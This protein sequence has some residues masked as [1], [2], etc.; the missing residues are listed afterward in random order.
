MTFSLRQAKR[1][2]NRRVR[3]SSVRVTDRVRLRGGLNLVDSAESIEAGELLVGKNYEPHFITQAY[4]RVAGYEVFDGQPRPHLAE[5]WKVELT[6]ITGGP[7][8]LGE[9]V[10]ASKLGETSQTGIVALYIVNESESDDSG[11]LIITDLSDD[12]DDGFTWVGLTST[13]S[14]SAAGGADYQG[15]ATEDDHDA[16][17]LAAEQLRRG[18]IGT[19]GGGVCAGS[20]TGVHIYEDEVYAFRNN[21]LGTAGTMWKATAAGWVQIALGYKIRFITG[22]VNIYEGDTI[23]G[24]LSGA[25][26]TVMKVSV[27][28]GLMSGG[29]G[30][31]YII[32]NEITAGP[33]TAAEDLQVSGSTVAV[34]SSTVAQTL[35]PDGKYRFRN[36]NFGGNATSFSMYGANGVGNAFEYDGT[37]FTL[38]ETGMVVDTP[39]HIGVHRGQLLL[40]YAGGSLQHSGKNQP[41]SFQP[42]S[43]ANEI[44]AGDEITGFI[45]EVGDVSFVYTRNKTYRLEGFVQENIQLKLHNSE[46]GAIENTIQRIG[47]SVYL[48]DRG[49]SSLPTTDTFGDFASN[50]ISIKIDPLV[51]RFLSS[52]TIQDSLIHRGKSLYRCFFSNNEC[53]VIGFSGNKVNGITTI[54]YGLAITATA[55]GEIEVSGTNNGEERVFIGS[56]DG[57]VYE[58]D[59]G[60]NFNGAAIEAY[61]ITAYHFSG[62]PEYSKRYRRAT[63]YVDGSGRTSL[64]VSADYDYNEDPLNFEEIMNTAVPLGGGR[65]GIARHGDFVYSAASKTDIRVPMNSHARNV[66]MIFYHEEANE[67]PHTLYAIHYH[68]SG[69]RII[70][71]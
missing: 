52:S 6:D 21:L 45:E 3:S 44:L 46:T 50:Q 30:E 57:Y 23:T 19:V 40:A 34:Y 28:A 69:R 39:S 20:V 42:I 18:V 58:T 41:L 49:F 51:Q 8:Q 38:I 14:G 5:Y 10:T 60:R 63:I 48:D 32:T 71:S 7:Y 54:D 62:A 67:E 35:A 64:K 4:R 61:L 15:E 1:R 11:Y 9:T 43:G 17:Q 16:A 56:T 12:V 2:H 47:R 65:Y 22:S 68:L 29:D 36:Y 55:N 37:T 26:C 31:G 66:S 53:I 70:R 24:A 27:T 25:S 33:F 59:V 13:A